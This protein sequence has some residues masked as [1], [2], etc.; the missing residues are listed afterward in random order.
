[1]KPP[2]PQ[3]AATQPHAAAVV[4]A[5][6]AAAGPNFSQIIYAVNA[7]GVDFI[8]LCLLRFLQEIDILKRQ[9]AT[10]YRH[11][12]YIDTNTMY[13]DC[14]ADFGAN[15]PAA[16]GDVVL[17]PVLPRVMISTMIQVKNGT[18]FIEEFYFII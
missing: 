7:Y 9:P 15:L 3:P 5:A 2:L 18:V 17:Q 13:I 1:M 10:K 8:G 12:M 14:R 4:A 6:A 16:S 11:T